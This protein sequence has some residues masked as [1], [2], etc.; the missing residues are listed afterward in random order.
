MKNTSIEPPS[1]F[2]RPAGAWLLI[3]GILGWVNLIGIEFLYAQSIAR[4]IAD[5]QIQFF[6]LNLVLI[7]D[8]FLGIYFLGLYLG[9]NREIFLAKLKSL[10]PSNIRIHSPD[11]NTSLQKSPQKSP[12]YHSFFPDVKPISRNRAFALMLPDLLISAPLIYVI[13]ELSFLWFFLIVE[14]ILLVLIKFI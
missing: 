13:P 11:A 14:F 1:C 4:N 12:N 9:S 5:F 3:K 2:I 10:S 7:Y 8:I 6:I